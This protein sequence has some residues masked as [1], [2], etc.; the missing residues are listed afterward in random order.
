MSD[1]KSRLIQKELFPVSA[2]Q[3]GT[4]FVNERVSFRT[5]EGYRVVS[6]DGMVLSHYSVEDRMA[7]AYAMVTLSQAGYADQ[8]DVARAFGYSARSLRRFESRYESGGL[9]ALGRSPGRPAGARTTGKKQRTRDQTILRLKEAEVSNREIARQLGID[10]KA[11][12]KRLRQL[13][14]QPPIKQLVFFDEQSSSKPSPVGSGDGSPTGGASSTESEAP[15]DEKFSFSLP[16]S[17]DADPL[18][19]SLDRVFAAIGLLDDAAPLFARAS[20]LPQAGVLVAIPPLVASGV[21]SVASRVY[22]SIGPAFYGLRTTIVAFVLVALLR[23][24]RPEWLKEHQPVGLGRILGLDRSPEVKTMRRKLTRLAMKGCAA[25]FGRELAQRRVAERGR[26][27]GFLYVDGHVR[28]YHGKRKIPKAYVTQRRRA[29]PATTDY[30][31]NDVQGDPLFVV[32][33]EANASLTKM[34]PGAL[35]EM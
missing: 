2:S 26:T 32:T 21:L 20:D 13:G 35:K 15:Q 11:V 34:L 12:R 18:D 4:V 10:E 23:I 6:V 29:L 9:Q 25:K 31:V 27:L 33:A 28:V 16:T 3:D 14:W 5:V 30:W 1:S 17:F 19:R 22:G 8:N 24:K 7:E